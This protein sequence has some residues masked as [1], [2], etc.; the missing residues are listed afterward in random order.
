MVAQSRLAA[1]PT[2]WSRRLAEAAIDPSAYV[3]S[4]SQIIGD[5]RISANVLVSPGTSIRADEGSPFHIGANTNIQDGVVIHGLQEGRVNGDDGQSYSVW[6]G[7]NT[8]ITHMALIHGPC[9]V[10]DDCFIGFRST[11]FNARVGKGCIVMMHA[12]V[13]DVEIPPG[14]YVPSGAVITTQQQANRLP[15][16]QDIDIHFAKHVIGIND[17]LRQGYRCAADIECI[18]PIRDESNPAPR[19]TNG[20]PTPRTHAQVSSMFM[21]SQTLDTVRSLLAQGCRLAVE[22]ADERRFK[23]NSW[24]SGP[25]IQAA[26]EPEAVSALETVLREHTGEYVRLIGIDPKAKR[27]V[28]ETIIQRPD[29]KPIEANVSGG[30]FAA[31]PAAP[32]GVA[33]QPANG[34]LLSPEAAQQVHSLLSQGYRIGTEHADERRFRANSWQSCAPIAATRAP[35]VLAALEGCLQEH[36][37]EYVRIIGIDP[38][39]KRRVAET[40]IQHPNGKRPSGGDAAPTQGY[41][42]VSHRSGGG[43]MLDA[44]VLDMV[45]SL[46]AQGCRLAVEFADERRFKA[47]S[48]VSGPAI[49]AARE[50]E[51]VSAL[52]TVLREHTGEYVRLIGIDPKAKRRVSETIIQ[53]PNGKPA[54]ASAPAAGGYS[55]A[56]AYAPGPTRSSSLSSEV[57]D[58]VRSLL[59]QGCRLAVEFADAR[60][61]KANSWVSGPTLQAAREPEAVSALETVLRE[62]TG[63]YVR[64][65]GIDPKAKRRVA[66]LIIQRP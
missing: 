60:R 34:G 57:L 37:G 54:P 51:A 17:A 39:A 52:E 9:Y 48:W 32:A 4:F 33:Y 19:G 46:L 56:P 6:V 28:S 8:S 36:T 22:F 13:Q 41:N 49:Q 63:E 43:G 20:K 18:V 61:F 14:K 47:N 58:M 15:D 62:H 10:G 64:L 27:R 30:K 29:G 40:I 5:V 16:A 65:I 42:T 23:A 50:P 3:H 31:T 45:R 25:A 11:I 53:R 2:P 26:R 24:V 21:T 55:P 7:S 59:A 35:E 12:L 66:E 38:K 44:A 1:P